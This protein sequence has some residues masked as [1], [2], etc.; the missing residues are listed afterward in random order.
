MIRMVVTDMDGTLLDGGKISARN[1]QAIQELQ[2][3]GIEF[4]IASGRDQKMIDP[5]REEYH[6]SCECILGNGAEYRSADGELLGSAYMNK[7][8]VQDVVE[9]FDRVNVHCMVFA[10]D[11][12]Y[13]H[14]DPEEA[15]HAFI[16][17]CINR[18]GYPEDIYTD[19]KRLAKIPAAHL[20]PIHDFPSFLAG[21]RQIIKVE[22][23]AMKEE[24]VAEAQKLLAQMEG[25]AYLS[26]FDDNVEVTDVSAQK[27]LILQKAAGLKGLAPEEV[28]VVGDGM[29][30][31]SMFTCFP[32][33]SCAVANAVEPIRNL[34]AHVVAANTEDGFAEAAETALRSRI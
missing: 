2:K 4:V 1:Y 34:A 21:E 17:R 3:A 25:T 10:T 11:G 32:Q 16:D 31:L 5:F 18:F 13:T 28:L 24:Q 12:T 19:E 27:G 29:N 7:A 20:L 15:K 6:L 14:S 30:D 22:G 23:F 26:S 8:I 9:V 33:H